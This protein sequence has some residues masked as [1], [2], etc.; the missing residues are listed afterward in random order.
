MK[1]AQIKLYKFSELDDSV[2]QKMVEEKKFDIGYELMDCYGDEYQET[3]KR[4]CEL[5]GIKMK[6]WRVGYCGYYFTFRFNDEILM[7][8]WRG[9]EFSA[10]EITGRLLRRWL[11]NNFMYN[12]L[13][14]KKYY[15]YE[16][17]W[18]KDLK[19]WNKQ[20]Y[21]RIFHE[22]WD[23]CPLTGTCYDYEIMKP[24]V[25]GLSKPIS[26]NYSLYDLVEDVLDNFF[27]SWHEEYEYW[28][29]NTGGCIED[30][31]EQRYDSEVFDE[32]GTMVVGKYEEVL[33]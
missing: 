17:G 16:A 32:D 11:N 4:F 25:D 1:R 28:C 20:R 27:K 7:G 9:K 18:N 10:K 5:M 2:K 6:D 19:R 26:D 29:D 3:L 8:D 12:A 31:L 21:S 15:K 13:P 24:I 30:E 22:S 14:R 23:E 33:S